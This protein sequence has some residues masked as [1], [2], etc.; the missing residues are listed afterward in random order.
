VLRKLVLLLALVLTGAWILLAIVQEDREIITEV[1]IEAPPEI[2][3]AVLTDFD[4]LDAWNP[5]LRSVRGSL[6]VGEKLEVS[7]ALPD[8][9]PVTIRPVVIEMSPARAL[10]WQGKLVSTLIFSGEHAFRLQTEGEGRTRFSHSERFSGLL[11]GPLIEPILQKA[12]QGYSAMNR[13]LK[14]RAEI[15]G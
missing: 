6:A 8:E 4:N 3:W 1:V 5:L 7:I 12:A 2:V 9:R 10:V 14:A 15:A 11:V 13:A